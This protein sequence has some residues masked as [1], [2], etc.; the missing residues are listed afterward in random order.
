[1]ENL[2]KEQFSRDLG[3][4]LTSLGLI[5]EN[6]YCHIFRSSC[7]GQPFIIKKYK[8]DDSSLVEEEA[9]KN[10]ALL[11]ELAENMPEELLS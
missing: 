6:K 9:L 7:D 4:E 3:M 2:T 11:R 8:G 10:I 1:M 5:Q